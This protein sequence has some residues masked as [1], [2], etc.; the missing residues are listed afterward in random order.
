MSGSVGQT[1]PAFTHRS[2]VKAFR[3]QGSHCTRTS[4]RP[5][6]L[7]SRQQCFGKEVSSSETVLASTLQ[8]CSRRSAILSGKD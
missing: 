7:A 5:F 2:N 8:Q 6:T 3:K 4:S 1:T